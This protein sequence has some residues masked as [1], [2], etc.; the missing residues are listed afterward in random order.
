MS[1]RFFSKH[2]TYSQADLINSKKIFHLNKNI[3]Y[4]KSFSEK[5]RS[6]CNSDD[7]Y[8]EHSD[9]YREHSDDYREHSDDYREHSDDYREQSKFY[10][11]H[12]I[13]RSSAC[14]NFNYIKSVS[15]PYN[16]HLNNIKSYIGLC[17]IKNVCDKSPINIIQGKTS[18]NCNT[19]VEDYI[20]KNPLKLYPH[21]LYTCD[22]FTCT[23]CE[24]NEATRV[25]LIVDEILSEDEKEEIVEK[26]IGRKIEKEEKKEKEE[27]SEDEKEEIVEKTIG[28]KIE[29]EEKKEKEKSIED[30][31][32]NVIEKPIARKIEKEEKKAI[33]S[34]T[35]NIKKNKKEV[36]G[37]NKKEDELENDVVDTEIL[38]TVRD[39][40]MKYITDERIIGQKIVKKNVIEKNDEIEKIVIDIGHKIERKFVIEKNDEIEKNII[41]IGHKIERKQGLEIFIGHK[42]ERKQRLEI[43]KS[44]GHKIER[45]QGLE[46]EKSVGYKIGKF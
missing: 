23:T 43:E 16:L 1:Y 13:Q 6:R 36:K 3:Q 8:R 22:N 26:T 34:I 11:G 5:K 19:N 7:D 15:I 20:C 18:Y 10:N 29:K 4:Y 21:G 31:R 12:S 33:D 41:N 32:E 17:E 42:I 14:L 40:E 37:K 27:V 28:R 44:I 45:K 35:E 38:E 24:V 30:V 39:N 9:D 46:T 2:Q 25:E